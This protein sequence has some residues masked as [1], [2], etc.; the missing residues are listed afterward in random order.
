MNYEPA[1][2]IERDRLGRITSY[3][4]GSELVRVQW[5]RSK[6]NDHHY[7][8]RVYRDGKLTREVLFDSNGFPCGWKDHK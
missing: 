3:T 7:P 4:Q 2:N 8:W 6:A 1:D 5:V